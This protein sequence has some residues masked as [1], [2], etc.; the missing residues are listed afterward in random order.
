M[1]R[2][3]GSPV[4]SAGVKS[5]TSMASRTIALARLSAS[6][7]LRDDILA[8]QTRQIGKRLRPA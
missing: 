7:R 5:S 4:S 6:V 3:S 1:D 8:H 2:R